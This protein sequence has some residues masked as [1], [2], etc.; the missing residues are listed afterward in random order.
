MSYARRK[1]IVALQGHGV[2]IL[3]EGGSHTVVRGATGKQSSVPRH[4]ALNRNT[5]RKVVKQLDLNWADVEKDL[6]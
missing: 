4:S 3:R 5:V 6:T 2:V 1:V